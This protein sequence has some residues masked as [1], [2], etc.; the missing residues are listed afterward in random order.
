MKKKVMVVDDYDDIRSMMKVMIELYGYEVVV[1]RDGSEAVEA[2]RQYHP[3]MILMDLA[4]PV[5][6]G[7]T[8]TRLIRQ[9]D[10]KLARVPIVAITGHGRSHAKQA[11]E[12][13]CDRVIQK[14]VNFNLLEPMLNKFLSEA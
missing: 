9:T 14:P 8:A 1:A 12:S 10:E 2:A 11:F 7:L 3:D 13:G 4:M 5:M 6:D